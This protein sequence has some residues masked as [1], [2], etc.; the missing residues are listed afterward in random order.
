MLV[1]VET[2]GTVLLPILEAPNVS[3]VVDWKAPSSLM[4]QEFN[5]QILGQLRENLDCVKIVVAKKICLCC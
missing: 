3:Y 2:N 4:E 1:F 5:K